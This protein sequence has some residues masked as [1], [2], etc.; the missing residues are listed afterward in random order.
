MVYDCEVRGNYISTLLNYRNWDLE[1]MVLGH[2]EYPENLEQHQPAELKRKSFN[3]VCWVRRLHDLWVC[4]AD[5]ESKIHV[6]SVVDAKCLKI[7][8]TRASVLEMCSHPQHPNIL[9]TIDEENTCRFI[10]VLNEETVYC[11]TEKMCKMVCDVMLLI[12]RQI[13]IFL[14]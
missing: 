5:N 13:P 3:T 11:F 1:V 9:C 10:N 12:F 7:I 4:A 14:Q 8:E 2:I 6:L